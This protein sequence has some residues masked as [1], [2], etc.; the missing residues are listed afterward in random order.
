MSFILSNGNG[1]TISWYSRV[2]GDEAKWFTF[3][4]HSVFGMVRLLESYKKDGVFELVDDW[5]DGL[6]TS[7]V[8]YKGQ[9]LSIQDCLYRNMYKVRKNS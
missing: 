6:P 3:Y 5:S 1:H 2:C 8:H 4:I 9:D 7:V